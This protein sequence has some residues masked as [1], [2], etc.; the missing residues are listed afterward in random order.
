MTNFGPSSPSTNSLDTP[1]VKVNMAHTSFDQI[2]DEDP[3]SSLQKRD[4]FSE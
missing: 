2:D 1:I 3:R 4:A